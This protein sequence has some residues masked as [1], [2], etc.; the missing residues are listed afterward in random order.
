MRQALSQKLS[1]DRLVSPH[2]RPDQ[3]YHFL[4][5]ETRDPGG[6]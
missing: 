1:M 5:E 2:R 3:E 4:D 6:K